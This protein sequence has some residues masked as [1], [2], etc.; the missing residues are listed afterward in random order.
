LY[1]ATLDR[2]STKPKPHISGKRQRLARYK[3]VTEQLRMSFGL[4]KHG[5]AN[6][7]SVLR[8]VYRFRDEAVHPSAN[9]SEAVLHPQLH[10]GVEHRFVMFGYDNALQ[11]V[12]AAL[13]FSQ[14]LPSR[15]MKRR[16]KAMREFAAYLLEVCTPLYAAWEEAYGAL[17]DQ[18]PAVG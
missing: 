5:T 18:S 12:R 1:A 10:V 17:L 15:D 13:A 6:L 3:R 9:F 14:I 11:L 4:R 7:Q 8:E 2:V 16:P